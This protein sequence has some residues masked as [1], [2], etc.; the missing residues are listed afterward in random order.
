[1]GSKSSAS[2]TWLR[3][4]NGSART[5]PRPSPTRCQGQSR[6]KGS[7]RRA[8]LSRGLRVII[9]GFESPS[10]RQVAPDKRL[11]LRDVLEPR[12]EQGETNR[13]DDG[14]CEETDDALEDEAA[15]GAHENHEYGYVDAAAEQHGLQDVVAEADGETPDGEEARSVQKTE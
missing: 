15:D 9:R 2:V 4:T 10:L 12:L 5:L 6:D 3:L 8:F 13:E 7:R 1:M 11:A 14:A